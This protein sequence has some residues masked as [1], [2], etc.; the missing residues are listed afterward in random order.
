[1][2]VGSIAVKAA[3]G[4]TKVILPWINFPAGT[5]PLLA[6]WTSDTGEPPVPHSDIPTFV[7]KN[8]DVAW[9]NVE[10]VL[11]GAGG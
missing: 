11:Y 2:L 4:V 9:R 6:V 1:M 10:S 3:P 8:N 5:I 7:R